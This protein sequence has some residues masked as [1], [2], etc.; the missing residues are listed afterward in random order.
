VVTDV[1]TERER[2]GERC[3]LIVE[4]EVNYIHNS[5]YSQVQPIKIILLQ[6]HAHNAWAKSKQGCYM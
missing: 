5:M 2:R 3:S 6:E 4:I 1:I